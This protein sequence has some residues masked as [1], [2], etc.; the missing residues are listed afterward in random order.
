MA[1]SQQ[2][3]RLDGLVG[4]YRMA[5]SQQNGRS[6]GPTGWLSPSRMIGVIGCVEPTYI[7]L[8]LLGQTI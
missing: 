7:Q 4:A 3:G 5:T 1:T 8:F 2:D 6:Y